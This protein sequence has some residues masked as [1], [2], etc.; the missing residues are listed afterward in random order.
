MAYCAPVPQTLLPVEQNQTFQ[1]MYISSFL[2]A[3]YLPRCGSHSSPNRGSSP[4]N[5]ED[6]FPPLPMKGTLKI[7]SALKIMRFK[8]LFVFFSVC[9][10]VLFEVFHFGWL[11]VFF[12]SKITSCSQQ[13]WKGHAGGCPG[14]CKVSVGKDHMGLSVLSPLS[15]RLFL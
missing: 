5:L 6:F 7:F 14:S 9:F 4:I 13:G 3:I 2:T 12:W 11:V 1:L 8:R 10:C 15:F